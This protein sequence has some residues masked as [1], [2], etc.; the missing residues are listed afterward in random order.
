MPSPLHNKVVNKFETILKYSNRYYD[1]Q[2]YTRTNINKDLAQE[3]E[4]F[5]ESCFSANELVQTGMPTIKQCGE[6]LNMSGSYLSDLLKLETGKGAKDHIHSYL[7]E[8]AKTS[9]LN[10]NTSISQIAFNLGFEYPQHFSKLFK[11]KT[12]N[13]PSE[14]RNLN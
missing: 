9:L 3:F 10:S 11:S 7:I 4:K 13:S 2:F 5:L 12:G 1:R 8:K 6:A 14:Y